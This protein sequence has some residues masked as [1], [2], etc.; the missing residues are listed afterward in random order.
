[1]LASLPTDEIPKADRE[2]VAFRIKEFMNSAA[3][4]ILDSRPFAP[5]PDTKK[6]L[7]DALPI[8]LEMRKHVYVLHMRNPAAASALK[9][10][11]GAVLGSRT[12]AIKIVNVEAIPNDWDTPLLRQSFKSHGLILKNPDGKMTASMSALLDALSDL[13]D[14]A[15]AAEHTMTKGAANHASGSGSNPTPFQFY[16]P[17]DEP[18]DIRSL[19]RARLTDLVY[20]HHENGSLEPLA[21]MPASNYRNYTLPCYDASAL[22]IIPVSAQA[23]GATIAITLD[24]EF[25]PTLGNM[26]LRLFGVPPINTDE[27]QGGHLAYAWGLCAY[28]DAVRGLKEIGDQLDNLPA[29][30]KALNHIFYSALAT[31]PVQPPPRPV[32]AAP[33]KK[34]VFNLANAMAAA[35]KQGQPPAPA[36]GTPPPPQHP[37]TG[38]TPAVTG[39]PPPPTG[40]TGPGA[41]M[42][43][44]KRTLDATAAGRGARPATGSGG[45]DPM[46]QGN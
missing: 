13:Q 6:T 34:M 41:A 32:I 44:Q 36:A 7:L 11:G 4:G 39:T 24:E 16:G 38:Q 45:L 15:T 17:R 25:E 29:I 33:K 28:S 20:Y 5:S 43:G 9:S 23:A 21:M 37:P 10:A 18:L 19:P 27:V 46:L 26:S 35:E 2:A 22:V 30:G 14:K 3:A 31:T 8:P 40:T 1:M 12:G 42:T